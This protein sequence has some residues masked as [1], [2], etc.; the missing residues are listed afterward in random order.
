MRGTRTALWC[1]VGGLVLLLG[2]P[3]VSA[4]LLYN[5]G[6]EI[7]GDS[8]MLPD[9]WV[10]ALYTEPNTG[11]TAW[12][13]MTNDPNEVHSG[14]WSEELGVTGKGYAA[15]HQTVPA[16]PGVAYTLSA[17][18]RYG[19]YWTINDH[20]NGPPGDR[21]FMKLEFYDADW[22]MLNNGSQTYNFYYWYTFLPR[23]M[24]RIAPPGTVAVRAVL[25]MQHWGQPAPNATT[26][27][28][29]YDTANLTPEPSSL[30]MLALVLCLRR[31]R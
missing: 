6:M 7:D 26:H 9:G 21:A 20:P 23:E 27:W 4:N 29:Q 16:Y 17:Y 19:G 12:A 5:P 2:N 30:V 10:K 22:N 14:L 15:I 13:E 11:S 1:L 8:D 24:T 25:G 18:I 28:F 31:S 3:V